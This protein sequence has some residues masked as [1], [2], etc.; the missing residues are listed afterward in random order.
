MK[1]RS[2]PL[3]QIRTVQRQTTE[4]FLGTLH[5][6]SGHVNGIVWNISRMTF[7]RMET[8]I[9]IYSGFFQWSHELLKAHCL[10]PSERAERAMK[11][12]IWQ[13]N[14]RASLAM[15]CELSQNVKKNDP[16]NQ[17]LENAISND[18]GNWLESAPIACFQDKKK[19]HRI[20]S[21]TG[22]NEECVNHHLRKL[23]LDVGKD[24]LISV[25]NHIAEPLK[26]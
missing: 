6:S 14:M 4:L 26:G 1:M 11:E 23:V 8:Y 3:I 21:Y 2:R 15:V 19:V 22:E 16:C 13:Q 18:A 24:C 25:M 20:L 17:A 9:E 12:T 7:W 5:M 10:L